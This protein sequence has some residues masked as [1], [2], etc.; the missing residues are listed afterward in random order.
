MPVLSADQ[1]CQSNKD[2]ERNCIHVTLRWPLNVTSGVRPSVCPVGTVTVTHQ[3]T[4][5]D[6][7]SVHFGP[8]IKRTDMLVVI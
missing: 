6:A 8:T 7:A 5:C 3:G 1:R 4:A 2:N